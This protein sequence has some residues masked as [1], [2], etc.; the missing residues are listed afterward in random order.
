MISSKYIISLLLL[1][2]ILYIIIYHLIHLTHLIH[3]IT[4]KSEYVSIP[5]N[6]IILQ[7]VKKIIYEN[8]HNYYDFT[9]ID[10]GCGDG[11]FI[12]SMKDDFNHIIGVE[13]EHKSY[14]NSIKNCE[15]EDNIS[16]INISMEDFTF[17]NTK[18]ILYMYEPLFLIKDR[19]IINNIYNKVINNY[20]NQGSCKKYILYVKTVKMKMKNFNTEDIILTH[21]FVLQERIKSSL[22]PLSN[23]ISLYELK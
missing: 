3:F 14:L 21:N 5:T 13:K 22:N 4:R 17:P 19:D 15:Y 10:F 11:Q 7:N 1:L 9:L 8:I 18:T 12:K 16:I 23:E 6:I 20:K 2:I